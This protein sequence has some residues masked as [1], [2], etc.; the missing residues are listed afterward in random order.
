MRKL[1]VWIMLI[2]PICAIGQNLSRIS[3]EIGASIED[4][5]TTMVGLRYYQSFSDIWEWSVGIDHRSGEY[6]NCGRVL[7]YKN[8]GWDPTTMSRVSIEGGV[9]VHSDYSKRISVG[10][11]SFAGLGYGTYSEHRCM[12]GSNPP[13]N[14][15]DYAMRGDYLQFNL[16]LEAQLGVR[17]TDKLTLDLAAGGFM[18]SKPY[19]FG[20][21]FGSG[22]SYKL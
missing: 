2:A 14:T 8:M 12:L 13:Y 1:L 16:R 19:T 18:L 10:A 15:M 11:Y 21:S 6:T 17:L 9:G 22:F 3:A 20:L 5:T 7:Y 4:A